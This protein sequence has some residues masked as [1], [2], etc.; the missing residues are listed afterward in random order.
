MSDSDAAG[1]PPD[2]S[3]DET[4]QPEADRLRALLLG[5]DDIDPQIAPIDP[6]SARAATLLEGV[7]GPAFTLNAGRAAMKGE[8]SESAKAR[9]IELLQQCAYE[10]ALVGRGPDWLAPMEMLLV[11]CPDDLACKIQVAMRL[12]D[13][14]RLSD[15]L[16]IVEP[17]L[18]PFLEN[19]TDHRPFL[20]VVIEAAYAAERFRLI[21][22]IAANLGNLSELSAEANR[23]CRRAVFLQ[24]AGL[25]PRSHGQASGEAALH[26]AAY[27]LDEISQ[28]SLLANAHDSVM[29]H[30]ILRLALIVAGAARR[31]RWAGSYRRAMEFASRSMQA[32]LVDFARN[33]WRSSD[34]P[35]HGFTAFLSSAGLNSTGTARPD[36][37]ALSD[38]M[39]AFSGFHDRPSLETA[40]T[41][42]ERA[43]DY[44]DFSRLIHIAPTSESTLSP[45]EAARA[46]ATLGSPKLSDADLWVFMTWRTDADRLLQTL[47]AYTG[48]STIVIGVGGDARPLGFSR[49]STALLARNIHLMT[50]PIVT[51]GDQ[52]CM[53][54]NLFEVLSAFRDRTAE[55]GWMQI[56]C[57]RTYPLYPMTS[58]K[59]WT[60]DG[61][62][63]PTILGPPAWHMEW[64]EEIVRDLP[65]VYNRAIE[66]AFERGNPEAFKS[67]ATQSPFYGENDDRLKVNVFNFSQT[68]QRITWD[69]R[70]SWHG[71]Y[72]SA[73]EA[74]VR[75]MSF[76]RLQ[77]YVDVGTETM[78]TFVRRL[79]P[80]TMRWAHSVLCKYDLRTGDPWV[81]V[82]RRFADRV[83]NDPGF[84]ELFSVMNMGFA[85]EMNYLDTVA[86]SFQLQ[87]DFYHHFQLLPS[88]AALDSLLPVTCEG[89]D[90]SGRA[91]VRKTDPTTGGGLI[92]FFAN[93]ILEDHLGEGLHWVVADG[94]FA[95]DEGEPRPCLDQFLMQRFVGNP[96]RIRDLLNNW[97]LACRLEANR[98]VALD[99]GRIVASWRVDDAGMSVDF[100]D[101]VLGLKHYERPAADA[102]H[103]TLVPA[104]LIGAHNGW[105]AILEFCLSDLSGAGDAAVIG[106]GQ[107]QSILARPARWTGAGT[108]DAAVL[109]AFA[110]T[111][112]S[113]FP[114]PTTHVLGGVYSV[115]QIPGALLALCTLDGMP[116]LMEVCGSAQSGQRT[117][118]HLKV[119][120]ESQ[121]SQWDEGTDTQLRDQLFRVEIP[122]LWRLDVMEGC[123]IV[124]LSEDNWIFTEDGARLGRWLLRT[125]GLQ[126]LGL[127]QVRMGLASQLR[128]EC[129]TW[130]VSGWG[131]RNMKD[132]V[133]FHLEQVLG[134]S[135]CG[136]LTSSRQANR[137]PSH[138]PPVEKWETV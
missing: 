42:W 43:F 66:E 132:A 107:G 86:A 39:E 48:D 130:R 40:R 4:E 15:V 138:P 70:T 134:Q 50:R 38:F 105:S 84:D 92:S 93:R 65:A 101:P 131:W 5:A 13:I 114:T 85:P 115:R 96:V 122:G 98:I 14:G 90:R 18:P 79:N 62:I 61:G 46:F 55:E 60:S 83:M 127:K 44:G 12:R 133:T 136:S 24:Q 68:P 111:D 69:P 78:S 108:S 58:L 41:V 21:E 77:E 123:Q 54:H 3:P 94:P 11:L 109:C 89:A 110:D 59:Y 91:F 34:L 63:A 106:L 2:I 102:E 35:E 118:V 124:R 17:Y 32:A 20:S 27:A 116:A 128:L 49:A 37:A 120:S 29:T 74:D 1:P 71:Y 51:W 117:A 80:T 16:P 64:P 6:A 87:N 22:A 104:E 19:A 100:I 10:A 45:G 72:V 97:S 52:T 76:A 26:A 25:G 129:G 75:W 82:S 53:F 47:A 81:Y 56:V 88:E 73:F 9:I 103:F 95:D 99:D 137:E 30:E 23:M 126:I 57:D 135:S 113:S 8:V 119:A 33:C 31:D 112:R 125:D 36:G 67:L 7:G 121:A 28:M